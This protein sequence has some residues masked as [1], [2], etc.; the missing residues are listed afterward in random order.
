M[1][2][3][4]AAWFSDGITTSDL[5]GCSHAT[6]LVCRAEPTSAAF[7]DVF[8][9]SVAWQEWL[10]VPEPIVWEATETIVIPVGRSAAQTP[11]P[12]NA[13]AEELQTSASTVTATG[14]SRLMLQVYADPGALRAWRPVGVFADRLRRR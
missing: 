11:E 13:A 8:L 3:F 5:G 9:L 2:E 7:C 14:S 1:T 10:L 4:A 6:T 12:L